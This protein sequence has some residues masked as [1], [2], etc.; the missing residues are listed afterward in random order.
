MYL[1]LTNQNF[2]ETLLHCCLL[3]QERSRRHTFTFIIVTTPS[4]L[5][6][7]VRRVCTYHE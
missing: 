7:I 4:S 3:S 2:K 5:W 1:H 6:K